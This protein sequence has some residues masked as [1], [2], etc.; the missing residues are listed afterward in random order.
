M[1][2]SNTGLNR[3]WAGLDTNQR[4]LTPMDLQPISDKSQEQE[5]KEVT[6]PACLP[7][8]TSLQTNPENGPKQADSY[9]SGLQEII[10][11][12]DDLPEHIKAA[13]QALVESVNRKEKP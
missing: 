13:I 12:W 3:Q 5:N 10:D 7:I 6:Q 9:P 8:Q 1:S 2:S 11:R 4:R